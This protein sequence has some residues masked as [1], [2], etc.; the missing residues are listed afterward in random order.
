MAEAKALREI[1]IGTIAIMPNDAEAYREASFDNAKVF[2]A[3]MALRFSTSSDVTQKVARA[4]GAQCTPD[5][6]GFN[7][8]DELQHRGR[9]DASRMTPMATVR[10]DFLRP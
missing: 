5:F 6:F 2:A 8:Q 1:S 9:L 3:K 10:R 4:Y 7:A